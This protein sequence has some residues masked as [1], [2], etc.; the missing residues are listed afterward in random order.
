MT[1][2]AGFIA[3]RILDNGGIGRV[4]AVFQRSAYIAFEG[5]LLCV[6]PS[7]L[8]DGPLMVRFQNFPTFR[9][10]AEYTAPKVPTR[11][12]RPPVPYG[13]TVSTLR[14]GLAALQPAG[15]GREPVEGLG[16]FALE[17]D[18]SKVCGSQEVDAAMGPIARL[19]EWLLGMFQGADCPVPVEASALVGLGPGLTPSGD[20]FLGGAIVAAHSLGRPDIAAH[21][22]RI[23]LAGKTGTISAA[24]LAAASEGA[25][26][27]PLHL[28][29]NDILCGR[30]ANLPVRLHALNTMGHSSGWDA[31]AG[32][33]AVLRAAARSRG[34]CS[35]AA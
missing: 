11:V 27:A 31:F 20:D 25:A 3:S 29:L 23:V 14:R 13:W 2:C 33:M 6:A 17:E 24:H 28:L 8:G 9:L 32:V 18:L 34:A 4:V 19:R 12:W 35:R 15:N 7:S 21:L 5:Q 22:Y 1:H 10:G 26:S 16:R 30:V